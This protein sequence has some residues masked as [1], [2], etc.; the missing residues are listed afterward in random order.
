MLSIGEAKD[1]VHLDRI[2][3]PTET[4]LLSALSGGD[5]VHYTPSY[6]LLQMTIAPELADN[7]K[8]ILLTDD[9][10]TR[11]AIGT[12]DRIPVV[13]FHKI[14][15]LYVGQ[16]QRAE[17]E[18]LANTYG[19]PEYVDFLVGIGDLARL[20]GNTSIYTGGLDANTDEDGEF[21]YFWKD[22]ITQVIFHTCTLMPTR[23]DVDPNCNRKKSHI[24]NDF[25][26]LIWNGSNQPYDPRTIGSEFNFINIVISPDAYLSRRNRRKLGS[27]MSYKVKVLPHEGLPA[28]SPASE[29]RLISAEM[30]PAFVRTI[31]MHCNSYAQV[32]HANGN[33]VSMWRQRLQRIQVLRSRLL[34]KAADSREGKE[35]KEGR[36]GVE[37]RGEGGKIDD[38]GLD[39]TTYI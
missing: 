19:S 25:V 5:A 16:G 7:T 4:N 22:K 6:M 24:G 10:A 3:G 15:I 28:V 35:V 23:P 32:H 33:Y 8:P 20:K 39:F 21:A 17:R 1:M 12:F 11:R 14:G 18:I 38:G 30:L 34:S 9:D 13:D 31:A 26:T 37:G 2:T 27:R 29:W 36:D